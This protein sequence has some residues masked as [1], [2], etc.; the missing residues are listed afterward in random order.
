[1]ADALLE[2]NLSH[3]SASVINNNGLS[4][5]VL[6]CEHASDYIPEALGDLG[7][8]KADRQSHAVWDIGARELSRLLSRKLDAALIEGCISRLVYDCN[9]PPN[10]PSAFPAQSERIVVP[11]NEGLDAAARH[12]RSEA[13]YV[14]FRTTVQSLLEQRQRGSASRPILVTVHSFAPI[15]HGMQRS[16]EIGILHDD[17]PDLALAMMNNADRLSGRVIALNEPY[18]QSD[19]VTHSLVIYGVANG[20]PNVMLEVR[21]DL[22]TNETEIEAMAED[23]LALLLPA[24]RAMAAPAQEKD[25]KCP[26]N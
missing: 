3:A 7:L 17:D 26:A 19:G 9:R 8:A 15:Y 25:N 11:G 2:L 13:V 4:P 24:L 20:L 5:V 6:V 10:V 21:N 23:L 14:P 22:L 12:E 18:A 1:V 16:V